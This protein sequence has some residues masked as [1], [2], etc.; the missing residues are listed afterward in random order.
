MNIIPTWTGT[1]RSPKTFC[2]DVLASAY[3]KEKAAFIDEM[4]VSV[5]MFMFS[6]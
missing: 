1:F 3:Q 5:D 4:T 2:T 6:L